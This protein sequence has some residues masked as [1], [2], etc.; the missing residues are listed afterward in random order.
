MDKK[1]WNL[2]S[3][4]LEYLST[5]V[6]NKSPFWQ[7]NFFVFQTDEVEEGEQNKTGRRGRVGRISRLQ[8]KDGLDESPDSN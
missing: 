3:R 5:T 8:L 6:S 4:F 2:I 7:Y 1:T